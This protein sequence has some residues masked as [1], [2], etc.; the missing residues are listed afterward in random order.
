MVSALY[1]IHNEVHMTDTLPDSRNWAVRLNGAL[2]LALIL[3]ALA[4]LLVERRAPAYSPRRSF[5]TFALAGMLGAARL[6]SLPIYYLTFWVQSG[7]SAVPLVTLSNGQKT[8]VFQGMQHVA[9]EEF[10][11]SVVF[12][13]ERRSQKATRYSTKGYSL[14]RDG[15][16]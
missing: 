5:V 16:N 1:S 7:S 15:L 6:A 4:G 10:Y 9:S 11:K 2:W 14:F 8:V 13:L 3:F 12:D